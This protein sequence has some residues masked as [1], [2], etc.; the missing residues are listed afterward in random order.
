MLLR[1]FFGVEG[2]SFAFPLGFLP[3]LSLI[4][5]AFSFVPFFFLVLGFDKL[6][7]PGFHLLSFFSFMSMLIIALRL[8]R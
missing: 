3:C 8:S 5:P 7:F 1:P 6:F 2:C 4:R